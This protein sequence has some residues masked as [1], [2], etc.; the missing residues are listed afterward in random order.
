MASQFVLLPPYLDEGSCGAAVD[1]LHEFLIE[2]GF[3]KGIVR[4]FEYGFI[5]K[6]RFAEFQVKVL[7]FVGVAADGNCGPD[8]RNAIFEKCGIDLDAIPARPGQLT[9]WY[10]PV[11]PKPQCWP[12][13]PIKH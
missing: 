1:K 11:S 9:I 12:Q 2:R 13:L 5:T 7:G 10:G 8:S 3:G 6:K 4:D